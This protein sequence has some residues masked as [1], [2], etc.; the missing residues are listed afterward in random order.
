MASPTVHVL[1]GPDKGRT[2][3]TPDGPAIIGRDA[4]QISLCDHSASRRHAEIR[5]DNGSWVLRDLNS[6]NGTFLNGQRVVTSVT[7]KHDDRIKVGDTLMVFRNGERAKSPAGSCT[8]HDL[9]DLDLSGENGGSSILAAVNGSA[10]SVTLQ[11]PE[12]AEAVAA[13]NVVYRIA[14]RIG[15]TESIE[16]FLEQA[17][18][19]LFKHLIADS[20]VLLMCAS[21]R[22]ELIPTVV[23][24][25]NAARAKRPRIVAS[26]TII[27]HVFG[28]REGVLCEN[29]MTDER[30][31]GQSM[32]DSIHTLGLHSV[33]CVPIIAN[34]QTLGVLYVDSSASQHTYTQGQLRLVVAVGRL[35]GMA[36]QN[37]RLLESRLRTERLA[38]A[39][40]AVAYLSHHIRNILQGLSSGADVVEM[41]LK[42]NRL[43]ATRSG[44]TLVRRSL[45]RTYDLAMNM[46]TFSK[47]REPC[48]ELAQINI[49]IMDVI[50]LVQNRADEKKVFIHTDL[51][52]VPPIP[53]DPHGMH[54]VIHNIL[55]NA[56]D[57]APARTGRVT[58]STR[59]QADPDRLLKKGTGF[60][61]T[62]DRAAEK[63]P[64]Q[65]A[66]TLFQQRAIVSITDNGPGIPKD[67]RTRIFEAFE[68]TKGQGGTGLGLA[69]AKKIIDELGGE[70]EVDSEPDKGT[71]FHVK[72]P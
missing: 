33:I 36:I 52:D 61:L 66:C 59:S 63:R 28:T 11:P 23:R 70:I 18:D 41:G 65:G 21:D 4:G 46:L 45:D 9:V 40:E 13:W 57:A 3:A 72:L 7:L 50:A 55:I 47:S 27:K 43:D 14:E 26:Q 32:H 49:V 58:I 24:F 42:K 10:E 1:Q 56:I 31:A 68:S 51:R 5:P 37:A 53:M 69:A 34:G 15:A 38:A 64:R 30:F 35:S 71:S 16:A 39:G 54:Q 22:E 62:P 67:V 29:A 20:L 12:T 2:F 17:A 19:I 6:S 44:W 25:K 8:I 48:I 60:E